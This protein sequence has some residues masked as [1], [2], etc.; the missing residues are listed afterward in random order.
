MRRRGCRLSARWGC[1]ALH[2]HAQLRNVHLI[3]PEWILKVP[4]D[5]LGKAR[6]AGSSDVQRGCRVPDE[7][8]RSLPG[9][10][11]DLLGDVKVIHAWRSSPFRRLACGG[12]A[13]QAGTRGSGDADARDARAHVRGYHPQQCVQRLHPVGARLAPLSPLRPA[14]ADFATEH[15][16]VRGD[17][18][19]AG[20]RG[21]E[22]EAERSLTLRHA[23]HS[24][25]RRRHQRG[26]RAQREQRRHPP[27]A[28]GAGGGRAGPHHGLQE[29]PLE[30]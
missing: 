17:G 24:R 10:A 29:P 16:A 4:C 11:S 14:H 18:G 2:G 15:G 1:A 22:V 27:K 30:Q 28:R 19:T 13:E 12:V 26:H 25:R 7:L 9:V 6:G 21:A 8:D 23:T 20:T 3:G 5:E